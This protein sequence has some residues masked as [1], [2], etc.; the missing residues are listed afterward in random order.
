MDN[1]LKR[2]YKKV[3]DNGFRCKWSDVSRAIEAERIVIYDTGKVFR[4]EWRTKA[5][6]ME[7]TKWFSYYD[8]IFDHSFAKAF[9]GEE[10]YYSDENQLFDDRLCWEY[11]LQQMVLEKEPLK[12]LE[13]FL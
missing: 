8:L 13:K 10:C 4:G 2:A 5:G 12:Y 9:W 6:Y 11:H 1:I 7:E 3:K